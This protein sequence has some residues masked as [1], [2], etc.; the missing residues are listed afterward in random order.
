MNHASSGLAFAL[1]CLVTATLLLRPGEIVPALSG[2]PIYEGLI[3][4]TL[5]LS[6]RSLLPHFQPEGLKRQPVALCLAGVFVMI[7]V[8]HLT[9]MYF[10]G[11]LHETIEFTK[12][13]LYFALLLAV[14]DRWSR[15]ERLLTVIAL[16]GTAVVAMCVVDYLGV[17]DLPFIEQLM[18]NNG[19]ADDGR[20]D[21]VARMRGTGIFSDPNDLSLLIVACGIIALAILTDPARGPL[22]VTMIPLLIVL[23]TG[24]I[25][26]RSRGGMLAASAAAGVL[27][28]YRYGKAAALALSLPGAL[29]LLLMVGRQSSVSVSE[30]TGHDRIMLWREGLVELRSKDILTGLGKG[31]YAD[32]AGL[33]AHNS[34]VHAFV[35]LGLIGGTFFFGL[36]F[37]SGLGLYRLNQPQWR[38]EHPGQARFLPFMAAIGASWA[39]GLLSLSRCYTVSTLMIVALCAAYLNLAGWHLRPRRLVIEWNR[40][41]VQRLIAASACLFV[42]LNVVAQVLT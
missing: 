12:A 29:G 40:W 11:M 15:F 35:E 5:L 39:V 41:H 14:V 21:R 6:F 31:T 27:L 17:V 28:M 9:H 4:G 1:F 2:V 24:L 25:C 23:A 18:D 10:G 30:G 32:I 13:A 33:V 20:V 19:V 26:T 34:F 36:F 22:R 7:P 16:T 37:F 3:L 8:S 42:A 38:I